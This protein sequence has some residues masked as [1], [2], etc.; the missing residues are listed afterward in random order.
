M[1]KPWYARWIRREFCVPRNAE[2]VSN[3]DI[4][5]CATAPSAKKPRPRQRGRAS[6]LRAFRGQCMADVLRSAVRSSF[7]GTHVKQTAMKVHHVLRVPSSARPHALTPGAAR[8]ALSPVMFAANPVFGAAS[9]KANATCRVECH[10]IDCLATSDA[11][12]F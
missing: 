2:L 8:S 10:A 1:R 7:A 11:K 4:T 6:Q 3:A 12:S 5:V 9:T